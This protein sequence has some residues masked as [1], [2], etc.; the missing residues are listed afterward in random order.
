MFPLGHLL[1]NTYHN[2]DVGDSQPIKQHLYRVNPD[3]RCRFKEQVEYMVQHD[4]TEP[5]CSVQS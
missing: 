4:V 2:V 3:K 5:I 1:I